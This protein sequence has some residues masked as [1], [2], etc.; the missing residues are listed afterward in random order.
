MSKKEN[1]LNVFV[2]SPFDVTHERDLINNVCVELNRIWGDF[3][4]LNLNLI[5]WETHMYPG[6]SEY[7]QKVINEQI[8]D[9]FDIFIAMFWNRFGTPTK[10]SESGTLEEIEIAFRK[11]KRNN[12]SV[13]IM[14]YFK[15]QLSEYKDKE[16][17]KKVLNLKDELSQKGVLYWE[18]QETKDFESLMRMHLS[19]VAQKWAKK[20]L[21][22]SNIKKQYNNILLNDLTLQ[23]YYTVVSSRTQVLHILTTN[24]ARIYKFSIEQSNLFSKQMKELLNEKNLIL[25]QMKLLRLTKIYLM[26][27][28]DTANVISSQIE[29]IAQARGVLFETLS[30]IISLEIGI[31]H[32]DRIIIIKNMI[33]NLNILHKE[34]SNQMIN[35]IINLSDNS[36][37]KNNAS[38][39]K[40]IE[41]LEKYQREL[42]QFIILSDTLLDIIKE[43]E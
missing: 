14:I 38:I 9:D 2:A 17:Q 5:R 13:D 20:Y 41:V 15:N 34:L 40:M 36:Y 37:F 6:A 43:L 18:F 42:N 7:S 35:S 10:K 29:P 22:N 12:K 39:K 28:E 23:D 3:L 4:G 26:S 19:M 31:N 11:L 16:Q 24:I 8:G 27:V 32:N 33:N 1:K 30:K 21:L 25:S